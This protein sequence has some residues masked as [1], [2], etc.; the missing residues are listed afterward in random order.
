MLAAT[1]LG[2]AKGRLLPA[3]IPFRFF[4][5]ATLFHLMAWLVLLAGAED[6]V[7]YTGGLGLPL[8]AIHLLTLGVFAMTAMGAAFQ[9]LPVAT[10]RPLSRVWPAKLVF[11][12]MAPGIVGLC[13]GMGQGEIAALSI[14]GVMTAAGLAI[15]GLAVADNL[16]RAGSMWLVAA[17]GW[18]A[19][20][21]L[22]GL[23]VAGLLLSADF[24]KGFIDDHGALALAH[25]IVA[26]YGFMGFLV[27]GFTHVL[28]PMFA[29]SPVPPR[30]I[31]WVGFALALVALLA[32]IAASLAGN[33]TMLSVAG[34]IALA[35]AGMHLWLIW[36]ILKNRMRKRLEFP[37]HLMRLGWAM[38]PVNLLVGTG[39]AA[40][41]DV[42]GGATLFG[43]VLLAGWLLSFLTGVLQR[44]MPFLA[45]MHAAKVSGKPPLMSQ[46]T[47]A[48][49]LKVHA[50]CHVAALLAVSGG[51]MAEQAVVVQAG[52]ASGALGAA[53]FAWFAFKVIVRLRQPAA[54]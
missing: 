3:S 22:A 21:A 29:L 34:L 6:T 35:A 1:F 40:G 45:S 53:A 7:G 39:L 9:L 4:A 18:V 24:S 13:Y 38:F 26:A 41:I 11:W 30:I 15:G 43:F 5:A 20:G 19:I 14:G 47:A 25:L 8:A 46:M 23:L 48:M 2:G 50:V 33:H 16:R 27:F 36:W 44:I 32:G 37:F 51:I 42:P 31:G 10:R 49:P 17:N 54:D 28:V 12:L 52:A